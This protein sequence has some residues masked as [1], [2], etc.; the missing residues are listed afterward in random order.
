MADPFMNIPGYE[1]PKVE[2]AIEANANI[3]HSSLINIPGYDDFSALFDS[4]PEA[5]VERDKKRLSILESEHQAGGESDKSLAGDIEKLKRTGG[6]YG[7]FPK[8]NGIN[9]D[10]D[11]DP[12]NIEAIKTKDKTKPKKLPSEEEMS[13]MSFIELSGL[14]YKYDKDTEKQKKIAPFEHR[15]YAREAVT[16]N[17]LLAP[18]FAAFLIPG[19]Q[20]AK[21]V[22][23]HGSRTGVDRRQVVE[24]LLG[25]GEGIVE[26]IVKMA[27]ERKVAKL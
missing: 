13:K 19:Y 27:K 18:L 4:S 2:K 17:P 14:R 26:P 21:A 12:I 15:A 6:G 22:G 9:V 3:D 20:V 1:P 7:S 5:Q 10:V 11:E 25:V 8:L 24:G 23:A 16:D